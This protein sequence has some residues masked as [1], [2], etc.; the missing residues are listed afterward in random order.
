MS[1]TFHDFI[2]IVK[3]HLLIGIWILSLIKLLFAWLDHPISE[4]EVRWDDNWLGY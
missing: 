1:Q 3:S 2:P 4:C